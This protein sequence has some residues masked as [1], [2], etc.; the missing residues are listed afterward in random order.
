VRLE[1]HRVWVGFS[2][3]MPWRATFQPGTACGTRLTQ[4]LNAPVC[5]RLKIVPGKVA[6]RGCFSH[7]KLLWK[8]SFQSVAVHEARLASRNVHSANDFIFRTKKTFPRLSEEKGSPQRVCDKNFPSSL[9]LLESKSVGIGTVS[10]WIGCRASQGL[11][12]RHS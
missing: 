6:W 2:D 8:V 7:R 12:L 9:G 10:I 3:T 1:W 4:M 5:V 11:S